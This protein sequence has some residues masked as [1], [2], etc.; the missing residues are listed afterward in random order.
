MSKNPT[1]IAI[2]FQ[3]RISPPN[4]N[5]CILWKG[6]INESG[7]GE[8]EGDNGLKHAKA[9]RVSWIL[10]RGPIPD[11]LWVLHKC[12][13]PACVNPDHLFLGTQKYNMQDMVNKGR[14]AFGE[15]HSQR[16]LT[17]E[18]VREIRRLFKEGVKQIT[19]C[20]IFDM[21]APV[22]NGIVHGRGWKHV[23]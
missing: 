23:T 12:D 18:R 4:E 6:Q 9:H 15:R 17:D 10:N 8:L 2:R 16:K 13:V 11:N 19:I 20:K 22:I 7:Y 3:Q 14:S 21:S 1:P 5:G